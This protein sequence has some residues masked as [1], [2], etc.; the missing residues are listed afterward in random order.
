VATPA[1]QAR[2]TLDHPV[3]DCD[4]H[5]LEYL[6]AAEPYLRDAL[7]DARYE[8]YRRE[9]TPLQ[10][11]LTR[12]SLAER[13]AGRVP[14]AG[15]WASPVANVV[16]L[17]SSIAPRLLHERLGELGIDFAVLYP[18]NT[19]GSAGAA[20][21]DVR[22]GLCAG[23]NAF[24]ADVYGPFADRLTVAGMI[25]MHT[26]EEAIAE[27]RHCHELGVKVVG[28]PNG[29]V[30][31]IEQPSP[32]VWRLPGQAHWWDFFGLDSEHDY[33]PVWRTARELGFSVTVHAGIGGPPTWCYDSL[34][35]W[36]ANHIGSFAAMNYPTCK[37][38]F[39]GGVTR[40]FPDVPFAFLECGVAWAP[41]L[42]A[43]T[44]GHWEKRNVR[45][46]REVY[47]PAL[48]D[49]DRLVELV[50]TY[51]PE[52]VD[53]ADPQRR[54]LILATTMRG[55]PPDDLDEFRALGV[56]RAEDLVPLLTRTCY[57]GCEADDPTVAAAFSP[58]N[59]FGARFKPMFSSDFSH[60]DAP[61]FG[62]VVPETV[63]LLEDGRLAPDD[64]RAFACDHA[65]ELFTRTNPDFFA[66]TTVE[67]Y[68]A[69]RAAVRA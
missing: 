48:L 25:P 15:W 49:V 56:E 10:Q 9:V 42:L 69:Q 33:D 27:L 5:I 35:S 63:E 6:P 4:G 8:A 3:I 52:L 17:A 38:L 29:V 50:S 67:A 21:E 24:L 16:D 41:T 55:S 43:D 45:R 51:A 19:L 61:D 20:D 28:I 13:R 68:A 22:R 66:G 7:G 2:A 57:F 60:F 46:L 54:E 11:I 14:Q 30:R 34:T 12:Q 47:D 18:T 64:F 31:P 58:A 1:E 39:L 53:A 62:D 65:I 37:S 36:M 26:P 44:I 40:R 23:Y 59:P 32:T